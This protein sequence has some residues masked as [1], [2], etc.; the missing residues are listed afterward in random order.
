MSITGTEGGEP[1]KV[2]VPVTDLACALYG[3]PAAVSALHARPADGEGQL[4]DVSLFDSTVA[5]MCS[6]QASARNAL[7]RGEGAHVRR[8]PRPVNHAVAGLTGR[9]VVCG[10]KVPL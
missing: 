7:H 9:N 8:V 6:K 2:G 4:I 5:S 10:K 1:V 3:A